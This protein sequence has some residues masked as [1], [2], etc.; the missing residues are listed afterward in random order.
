MNRLMQTNTV[1]GATELEMT[2][3]VVLLA[4]VTFPLLW[5][6]VCLILAHTGGWARLAKKYAANITHARSEGRHFSMQSGRVGWVNYNGCLTV[7]TTDQGLHV[8]VWPMFRI[9]HPPLFIPWNE[10]R[11]AHTVRFLWVENVKF[12]VGEPSVATMQLAKGIFDGRLGVVG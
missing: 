10:V 3:I 5:C 8:A 1:I 4:L 11:G 6:G 9:G 2:A 12:Q 7:Q